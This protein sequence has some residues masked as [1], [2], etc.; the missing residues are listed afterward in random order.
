MDTHCMYSG[1]E[2]G[3]ENRK[4]VHRSLGVHPAAS[5]R[6]IS[7]TAPYNSCAFFSSSHFLL[8]SLALALALE[9]ENSHQMIKTC[10]CVCTQISSGST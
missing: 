1:V 3:R 4:L 7:E 2:R 8:L 5:Y 10:A 9:S 6:T